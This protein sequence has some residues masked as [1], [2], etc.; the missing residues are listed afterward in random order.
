MKTLFLMISILWSC[1]LVAS[2]P[3]NAVGT[4]AF[5]N[6][7]RLSST[8]IEFLSL[9][10]L[11]RIRSQ[12]ATP[13]CAEYNTSYLM[14]YRICKKN[15]IA[16]CSQ[17]P[18][19]IEVN[20]IGLVPFSFKPKDGK[21]ATVPSDYENLDLLLEDKNASLPI[22]AITLGSY[23]PE[24]CFPSDIWVNTFSSTDQYVA[25]VNKIYDIYNDYKKQ[26]N[27]TQCEECGYDQVI[28]KVQNLLRY[29]P[30]REQL[31]H[32]LNGLDAKEFIKR[33]LFSAWDCPQKVIRPRPVPEYEL[34]N[35]S[36]NDVSKAMAR[37]VN[38]L[39]TKNEPVLLSGVCLLRD[40]T[41]KTCVGSHGITITGFEYDK[42]SCEP[43]FDSNCKINFRVMNSWGQDW[44]DQYKAPW[45]KGDGWISGTQLM[46]ELGSVVVTLSLK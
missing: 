7:S 24:S 26:I 44:Q 28:S 21:S 43:N 12:G 38:D 18:S 33:L 25:E 5:Q 2:I 20:P 31:K 30:S 42:S 23:Y 11:P 1:S 45:L 37:I 3:Q 29:K 39:K 15:K 32:A 34:F 36:P 10:N 8:D 40:K 27:T 22:P 4:N 17:V 13:F 19:N 35:N 16:N 46:K 41:T 6:A 9:E 14:Q